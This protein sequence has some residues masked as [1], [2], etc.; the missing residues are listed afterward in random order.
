MVERIVSEVE[1]KIAIIGSRGIPNYY[2]GFEAFTEN[3]S[4]ELV[5]RNFQ[6]MVSCENLNDRYSPEEYKGVKIFYFPIKQPKSSSLRMIYEFLYDGYSLLWASRKS[7][8]I[9]M[10]GYSA[11][12]F[13]F[14]PKIFGKKL[15][16]NP[17]GLEWKRDKFNWAIKSLLKFSER[18]MALW[19]DEIIADSQTMKKYIDHKYGTDCV[20]I[21][22]G[23]EESSVSDWDAGNLPDEIKDSL[24][25]NGYWLVVARLEPENNIHT[26]IEAYLHSTSKKPLVVVGDFSSRSYEKSIESILSNQPADKTVFFTGGIYDKRQLEMLRQYCFAYLHGHSVGGTNPS[27]LEAMIMK[28][29]IMGHDNRFNREVCA[30]SA[31]YFKDAGELK[32]KMEMIENNNPNCFK[33]KE[34]VYNEVKR[35]S[36]DKV[37]Q[38]YQSLFREE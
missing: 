33:L 20:F 14:I 28:N 35:Y 10:L 31:I 4:V 2:G 24:S 37:Y 15:F 8:Y 30:D 38:S 26:I 13:F 6:V 1:S 36:W 5:D 29:I 17:G 11:A 25:K 3:L 34:L 32:N 16:V 19:A 27:L 7:D 12:I 18:L 22:Y 21:P 23:I 9:Y